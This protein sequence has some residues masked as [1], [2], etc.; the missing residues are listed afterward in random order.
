MIDDNNTIQDN[1]EMDMFNYYYYS[2]AFNS[3]E[4]ES[5]LKLCDKLKKEVV[6]VDDGTT[7]DE[8]RRTE[9]GMLPS[10]SK[11]NWIYERL[12]ELSSEANKDMNWDFDLDGMYEDIQ[13]SIY[14]DNGG[15]YQWSSDIGDGYIHRKLS[16]TLQLSTPEEYEGGEIEYNLGS[17]ILKAPSE[18]GTLTIHPSY[19]LHRTNPIVS[20][21]KKTLVLWI[22]GNPFK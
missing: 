17:R 16:V 21:V 7:K 1:E 13:Y 8:V 18:S 12:I 4:I 3:K 14:H 2:K 9:I 20:G 10:N 6:I 11:T 22:S 5:I 15:H 19:L